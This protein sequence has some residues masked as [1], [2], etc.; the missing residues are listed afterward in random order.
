MT[1]QPYSGDPREL[2]A[3]QIISPVR[4]AQSVANMES[5]GFDTFV[6]AG[7]GKTLSDLIKK[8]GGAEIVT[9]AENDETLKE[10]LA[11]LGIEG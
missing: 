7:A 10:A 5:D 1:A 4:W 6:E 8:I 3:K 11:A 2:L 9:R